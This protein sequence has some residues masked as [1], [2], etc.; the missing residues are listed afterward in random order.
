MDELILLAKK[1]LPPQLYEM[2]VQTEACKNVQNYMNRVCNTNFF[3]LARE[4]INNFK[5]AQEE[6]AK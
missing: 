2:F 4:S 5:E 3:N 1:V 6:D